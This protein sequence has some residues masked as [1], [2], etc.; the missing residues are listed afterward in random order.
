LPVEPGDVI[1]IEF[2]KESRDLVEFFANAPDPFKETSLGGGGSEGQESYRDRLTIEEFGDLSIQ[3][4]TD[5]GDNPTDFDEV[6]ED[7]KYRFIVNGELA[8]TGVV[9]GTVTDAAGT[10]LEEVE[11]KIINPD[12][13]E[14]TGSDKTNAKGEYSIELE[15]GQNYDI[16]VK[17]DKIITQI[18]V[19]A[20]G[21]HTVPIELSLDDDEHPSG[22]DQALW[23]GVTDQS[24]PTN[25][26]TFQDLVDSIQ[27]YQD[28]QPVNGVN[29]SLQDL[30]DLIQW[31]QS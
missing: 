16:F 13:D 15:A 27:A 9:T 1:D 20:G 6:V 10:P 22:V 11:V 19:E 30:I 23:E 29:L 28:D 7:Q 17:E 3:I 31:Y 14:V 26:L 2:E 4:S 12:T 8:E 24:A 25:E 18:S 5:D 21:T